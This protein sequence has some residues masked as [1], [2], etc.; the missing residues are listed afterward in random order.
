[1]LSR[2]EQFSAA[3]SCIYRDIQKIERDEMETYGFK[4]AFAQYL[5]VMRH[6]PQGLTAAQIC[7]ACD[8]DKAAVSRTMSEMEQKGL[9]SRDCGNGYRAKLRLTEAGREAARFV[10]RQATVAVDLAG[11]GLTDDDRKV[12]YAALDLIAANLQA[13]SHEGL[14]KDTAKER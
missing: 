14:P 13:I 9:V 6:Y 1:M 10:G 8:K 11:K 2:Y 4:G 12:F 3:I 5:M 7:E